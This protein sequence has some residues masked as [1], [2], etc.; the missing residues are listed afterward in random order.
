[1][2]ADYFDDVGFA[3]L[4]AEFGPLPDGTGLRVTLVEAENGD[5][6]AWKP[7]PGSRVVTDGDGGPLVSP[8]YSGHAT[9]SGNRLYGNIS[10]TPGIGV[11]P[12]PAI[13]AYEA[14]DWLGP[15]FL[16]FDPNANPNNA[17]K[18]DDPIE[19]GQTS[20]R[21]ANHSWIG[22]I[23]DDSWEIQVL[24]RADWVV[25][26]DDYVQVTGFIGNSATFFGT[27]FN[28]ISVDRTN[29][30]TDKGS[31]PSPADPAYNVERTRPDLVA[32]E[33]YSS[34]ATPRVA[35]AAALLIAA[36]RAD[37][38]LSNGSTTNRN[39][40]TIRNAERSEVIR[41]I[42]MAGADRATHNTHPVDALGDITD[43]RIDPADRTANGLDRRFGAGQLSIYDSYRIL[44][45]GEQDSLEDNGL[46]DV[47]DLGFD[48]DAAFGGSGGSNAE[49]TYLFSTGA[50]AVE[51]F[52]TLAWNIEVTPGNK[53][54]FTQAATVRDLN[55][56]LFD[57]S[58]SSN[59]VLVQESTS[60]I[61]NTENVRVMLA[62]NTQYA[63]KVIP[64]SG[65]GPFTWDYA[66]AWRS[67]VPG[68]VDGDGE[69]S[70]A[71]LTLL[72]R[73]VTG[74]IVLTQPQH[75]RADVTPPG[76][77]GS[78][79]VADLLRMQQIALP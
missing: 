49:A 62:A 1:M 70:V 40:D 31:H 51:F 22:G 19:P 46:G 41:A 47:D 4:E 3:A 63:L 27:A 24:H 78:L 56:R 21:V 44:L 54:E 67:L 37:P 30:P 7:D 32:P 74:Q 34:S 66:L 77:D 36:S 12:S 2:R 29:N 58:N 48:Y 14:N 71:D 75:S 72:Q 45:A 8:P 55:L 13:A 39:G 79:T 50:E 68:D 35:S 61:D 15:G 57:V 28:T 11:S 17:P 38:S 18:S 59:P 20:S 53:W 52:A 69:V 26:R 33:K 64:A 16:K 65:Q 6:P 43:Y 76:G 10:T 60:T 5:P 23:N 9:G 25:N 73:A 42:L